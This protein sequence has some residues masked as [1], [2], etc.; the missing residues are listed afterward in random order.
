MDS[1][2]HLVGI[3]RKA[4]RLEVGEEPVGSCARARQAKL[5]LVA[6]DAADNSARRASHFAEAGKVPWARVPYTKAELGGVL[7]RG[8]CAMLA[9]T[10]VG[11]AAALMEKLSAADPERYGETARDLSARA[12]KALQRQ[13]EQRVHEKKLQRGQTKPWSPPPKER[14]R[15]PH[16]AAPPKPAA[17]AVPSGGTRPVPRGIVSIKKK[18]P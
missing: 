3:A 7:G 1:V 8:S 18:T 16:G 15:P 14:A 6:G 5:I 11:L 13:K 9:L 12:G 2:L 4:G 17:P 10:D